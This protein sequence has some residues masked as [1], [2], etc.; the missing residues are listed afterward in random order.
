MEMGG[1]FVKFWSWGGL[2]LRDGEYESKGL[3]FVL[4]TF[5]PQE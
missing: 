5:C 4:R 2:L 1:N 3:P